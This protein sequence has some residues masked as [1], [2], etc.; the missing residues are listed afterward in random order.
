MPNKPNGTNVE[1]WREEET[2]AKKEVNSKEVN[3][4]E[5]NSEEN[6]GSSSLALLLSINLL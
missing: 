2:T 4:K 5:V 6:D 1:L 3:S